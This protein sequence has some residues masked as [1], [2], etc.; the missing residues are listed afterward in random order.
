MFLLVMVYNLTCTDNEAPKNIHGLA[1]SSV[2][3]ICIT[4]FGLI[5]G[6][7]VSLVSLIG[8]SIASE[9]YSDWSRYIIG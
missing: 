5:S 3:L 4:A 2:S 7:C 1:I 8:P 6:G 9:N